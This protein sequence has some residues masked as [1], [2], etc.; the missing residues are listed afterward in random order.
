MTA[1]AQV[2]VTWN[3][4]D[5]PAEVLAPHGIRHKHRTISS[6]S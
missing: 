1:S 6:P 4:R 3:I 2:I 5:F